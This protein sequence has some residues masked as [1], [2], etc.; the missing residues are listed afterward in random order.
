VAEN[1][2]RGEERREEKR[3]EGCPP[4][5]NSP[6]LAVTVAYISAHDPRIYGPN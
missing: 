2:W 5:R 3:R 6:E 4:G 1:T